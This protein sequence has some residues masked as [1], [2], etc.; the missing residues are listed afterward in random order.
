M[1]INLEGKRALVTGAGSGIGREVALGLARAGAD[2]V[3][4]Y[5]NNEQG[6]NEVVNEIQSY[7]RNAKAVRGNVLEEKEIHA[8]I[9]ETNSFF[10]GEFHIL[11]NN[12]GHL[13]KRCPV[14]EMELSLWRHIIDVNLTS[15]F[16]VSK[17]SIPA[18]KK[19]GGNIVNITSMAAHNGGGPGAAAY[20]TSKGGLMTFTK[21]LAKE[22]ASDNISVNAVSPGFIGKTSFHAT[23]TSDDARRGTV[24]NTPLNREG[25]PRDVLGAVIYL[26]S[27]LGDFI[28]GETIEVNG[29]LFMR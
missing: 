10:G 6:A 15:A 21:G 14:E 2:V 1:K 16:L 5:G 12:A 17:L 20:A 7:G 24:Q 13:V 3:V 18:L 29:G 19:S 11:I 23:F 27:E 9:D 26:V 8:L 4:H 28:T 22:V 25:T